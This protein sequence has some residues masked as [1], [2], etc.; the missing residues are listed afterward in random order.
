MH[1]VIDIDVI[2][3]LRD[4]FRVE[5]DVGFGCWNVLKIFSNFYQ[6]LFV[7][8]SEINS[9][10]RIVLCKNCLLLLRFKSSKC[11]VIEIEV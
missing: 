11:L 6:Q 8:C 4:I 5:C 9:S 3:L 10:Y 1:I 2:F 7:H